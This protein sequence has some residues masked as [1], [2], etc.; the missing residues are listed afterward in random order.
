MVRY[1]RFGIARLWIPEYGDPDVAED[2]AW[3][4]AYSPYHHVVDD[5]CYPAMLIATGEEDSRVDPSHARKFGACIQAA[6]SCG[7][8]RPILVRVE[9]RAGHGQGKPASKQA[10][11]AADTLAFVRWQ[12]GVS[13]PAAAEASDP[14]ATR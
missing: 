3:L 11:E 1:H 6:T 12:L 8:E 2:F 7:D 9:T 14:S 10:D 5:R 13:E 4:H